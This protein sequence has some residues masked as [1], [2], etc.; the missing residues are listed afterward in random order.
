MGNSDRNMF[1]GVGGRIVG[2]IMALQ[3]REAEE[4]AV[5]LLAP[6]ADH[7]VLVIGFGP[8]VGIELLLKLLGQGQVVGVD[9]SRVMNDL[10]KARNRKA[11]AEG[12]VHLLP[13]TAAQI[14]REAAYFDGAI[15]VNTLQLCEPI[16]P[17]AIE[18]ARVLRPGAK[19]VTLTHDWAIR[20]HAAT[21]EAW[22]HDHLAALTGA[23]FLEGH[24]FAARAE[25]GGSIALIAKRG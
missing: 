22:V 5:A 11:V 7:R 17:T 16:D 3:N 20:K 12:R 15:A 18:L 13:S 14:A 21:V 9:P 25:K 1:D 23:G 2:P 24:S 10:A 8:G 6:E 19:L 4:E